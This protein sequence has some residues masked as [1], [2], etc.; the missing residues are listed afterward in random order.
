[1]RKQ[2]LKC[3]TVFLLTVSLLLPAFPL[4]V[5]A[6][7]S[8]DPQRIERSSSITENIGVG[9]TPTPV[10]PTPEPGIELMANGST[11]NSTYRTPGSTYYDSQWWFD[12]SASWTADYVYLSS[13]DT[14]VDGVYVIE[15]I[16]EELCGI[17]NAF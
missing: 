17:L 11:V 2:F 3:A 16:S 10:T 12:Y 1:M 7:E 9:I 15:S 13:A 6:E 14:I 4:F 5:G 8:G